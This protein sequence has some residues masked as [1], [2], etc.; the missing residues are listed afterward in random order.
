MTIF[1]NGAAEGCRDDS[2]NEI[3]EEDKQGRLLHSSTSGLTWHGRCGGYCL[4][5]KINSR[6]YYIQRRHKYRTLICAHKPLNT[7]L[8]VKKRGKY[9]AQDPLYLELCRSTNVISQASTIK[10]DF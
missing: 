5:D 7:S 9:Y 8:S 1:G 6:I 10:I 4:Y 2:D 3:G